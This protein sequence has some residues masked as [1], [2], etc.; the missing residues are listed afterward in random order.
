VLDDGTYDAFVVDAR[1]EGAGTDRLVHL[2]LTIISGAR[3]GE[4]VDITARGMR[5]EEFDLL[6]LPATITV[7][8]GEPRVRIDG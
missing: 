5:G 8:G 6:G 1:I 4:I 2:E 7:D 3:K